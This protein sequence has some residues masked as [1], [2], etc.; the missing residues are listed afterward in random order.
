[1][2]FD[3]LSSVQTSAAFWLV[4]LLL[5]VWGVFAYR[6][7]RQASGA[8]FGKTL[9]LRIATI[10]CLLLCTARPFYEEIVVKGNGLAIVDI[11]ESIEPDTGQNLLEL[12]SD[13]ADDGIEIKLLPTAERSLVASGGKELLNSFTQLRKDWAQLNI[14]AS[15]VEAGLRLAS[16][17]P[18]QNVFILSD[19]HETQGNALE[20]AGSL[21]HSGFRLYPLTPTNAAAIQ[22]S[23]GLRITQLSAPLVAPMQK[24]VEIRA[25]IANRT[26]APQRARLEIRHGEKNV[27]SQNIQ[28]PPGQEMVVISSSDAL[29]EGIHEITAKLTPE[30][31]QFGPSSETTYLA[32]QSREKILL[33][34]GS[35][36][37]SK[38]IKELLESQAYRL[39]TFEGNLKT[40]D[41]P[42]PSEFSVVLLNNI[43]ADAIPSS[44]LAGLESYAKGG[45][46]LIMIGGNR[47]FGL[48]GYKG[49]AIEKALPVEILPPETV[50]KR[51]NLGVSLV[52]D[53]SR[54]MA[55]S[56]KL[57]FAKEAAREAI[58]ALK[59]EDFASVI[60]F[61]ASPFVVVEMS[62]VGQNRERMLDRIGRL[63]PAGR[64]NL[65]PAIDEAR[66]ALLRANAGRKHM[67]VL[68]DGKIPDEGPFYIELVKQMRIMGITVSTV[69][70]GADADPGMLRTMAD[71]GGGA[72]YQ[73]SDPRSLPRIFLTDLKVSTGE[74]TLKENTEFLV[75]QGSGEIVSTEI[76]SFP[77]IR[78]YVQTKPRDGANLE[79]VAFGMNKAEPLLASW[80]YGKGKVIAFTSDA[81]GRWSNLWVAWP[82]FSTF[83]T[84]I[85]D[86][87]RRGSE[88]DVT[89]KFDLR[90][91]VQ[92]D[93]LLVDISIFG[94]RAPGSV[95]AVVKQP[96]GKE[97]ELNL[98]TLNTGHYQAKIPEAMAGRHDL[99]LMVDKVALTPVAFHVSGELFGERKG[100]GINTALLYALAEKTGGKVNPTPAEVKSQVYTEITK[101]SL[102]P[103]FAGLALLL[104]IFEI[105]L[106]EVVRLSKITKLNRQQSAGRILFRQP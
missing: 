20:L 71:Q 56:S 88:L 85:I 9:A 80:G 52:L 19:G 72:F 46:G 37:D 13:Y 98:D 17:Q 4:L 79:L 101:H 90:T 51:V 18:A 26:D 1:M 59:D 40:K 5:I 44:Y 82:R 23:E 76:R 31:A 14:G 94:E 57:D 106:R 75:R 50:K 2:K 81:N 12:L 25:S 66:R 83:W 95:Q 99:T 91:A 64:T 10:A 100:L 102:I 86:W 89:T 96:N 67:I 16:E 70:L 105:I 92:R 35:S 33:L 49:S 34:S 39:V 77:P 53:K 58:R 7:A 97:L 78:G 28:V 3:A 43:P 45:G 65:L 68:T 27:Y 69:L 36:D 6:R 22:A 8:V 24:S 93:S 104:F 21:A 55:D 32:S 30:S 48:G 38:A 63:F 42:Q 62:S 15:S 60:G 11:S 74:Q 73:T 54:S 41:L 61:D 29:Q 84:N 47:S 103:Y 87:T